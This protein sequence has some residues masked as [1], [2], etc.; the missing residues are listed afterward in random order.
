MK[1]SHSLIDFGECAV[2]DRRDFILTVENH[3]EQLPVTVNFPKISQFTSDVKSVKLGGGEQAGVTLSFE[4][5]NLGKF[6]ST[7]DVI[8]FGNYPVPVKVTGT[9]STTVEK[10]SHLYGPEAISK[11]FEKNRHYIEEGQQQIRPRAYRKNDRLIFTSHDNSSMFHLEGTN[12]SEKLDLYYSIRNN[13]Q[14]YNQYLKDTRTARTSQKRMSSVKERFEQMKKKAHGLSSPTKGD[15]DDAK[16]EPPIDME[17]WFRM[18]QDTELGEMKLP[19]PST[20]DQLWVT[21]PIGKYEPQSI[22]K[23]ELFKPD[24]NRQIKNKFHSKPKSNAEERDINIEL[25]PDTLQKVLAG[26]K[27]IDF[28]KIYKKSK[29]YKYFTVRNELKTSIM[30]Q[31]NVDGIDE[32]R[33]T[34]CEAQIIPTMQ[35]TT[36]QVGCCSAVEKPFRDYV[37]YIINQ[38]HVFKFLVSAEIEPV[39]LT[40][41]RS[42][43]KFIFPEN[44]TEMVTSEIVKI[45]N[46]GN[47]PGRFSWVKSQTDLFTVESES[48]EVPPNGGEVLARITYKPSGKNFKGEE[49][50]LKMKVEDGLERQLKCIGIV[51]E[52][53]CAFQGSSQY[54]FGEV[55]VSQ[56]KTF[57]L[58]FLNVYKNLAVFQVRTDN[59]PHGVNVTPLKGKIGMDGKEQLTVTVQSNTEQTISFDLMVYVRGGQTQ[60]MTIFGN[61]VIPKVSIK[62]EEF[63]FGEVLYDNT[64]ELVMTVVNESNI[65]AQL[66]VDLRP[67]M[68]M[69]P[70]VECLEIVPISTGGDAESSIMQSIRGNDE[71]DSRKIYFNEFSKG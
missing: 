61:I 22:T 42:E 6:A 9:A 28:G 53:K 33:E 50:I 45:T 56:M 67:K 48:N 66:T 36:F 39:Q 59:L 10:K 27:T 35:A 7:F 34:D 25:T 71:L 57:T 23:Y 31:L 32:L 4:P 15:D 65:R 12:V 5:K 55:P 21:R 13:K 47:A 44:S 26:P 68:G 70:G 3:N 46:K 43:I 1:L 2:N 63:N 16:A 41:D 69:L 24:P 20:V 49:E 11:D 58:S 64:K 14:L 60:K 38:K 54:N 62:E 40:L 29:A 8:F 37:T 30:V 19:L 17:F 52:A 51:S 18:G